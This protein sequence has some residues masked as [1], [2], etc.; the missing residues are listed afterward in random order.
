MPLLNTLVMTRSSLE[1]LKHPRVGGNAVGPGVGAGVGLGVGMAHMDI[2]K[3]PPH[4]SE[5][6]P[7]HAISHVPAPC[8]S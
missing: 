6:S 7:A 3:N 8:L 4:N 1:S 2:A 5:A